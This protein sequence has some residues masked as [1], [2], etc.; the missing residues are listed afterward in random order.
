MGLSATRQGE[1][2]ILSSALFWG[3]FPV[4][5]ILSYDRL[6]P[7]VSLAWSTLFSALFFAVVLTF[8]KSWS[9]IKNKTA[10]R[11]ILWMTLFIGILYYVFFFFGLKYTS[12]G[13]ASIIAL[14]E[15]LASFIFFHVWRKDYIPKEHIIGAALMLVGAAVVLFP[16]VSHWRAGDWLILAAVAV[17]PFGN[18][19]Q[20]RARCQVSSEVI[21]FIRALIATPVIFL[22]AWL[23]GA[24][25]AAIDLRGSLYFL[26]INGCLLLGLTKLFWIEGIHRISVTK[27]NALASLSPLMTL[28]FAW[29]LLHNFPTVWQ[30]LA[31][32]PM[33]FG[34]LLLAR[35][36]QASNPP[37]F[38]D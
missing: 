25:P 16:N 12:A 10:R 2:F 34:V 31:L 18:F 37:V 23:F 19:F 20:Q 35:N 33:F 4:I 11:D 29:L 1:S 5:T 32:V 24:N 38:R 21:M 17:A 22:L 3:L 30:L 27:A 28:L 13:N 15:V 8:K 9:E 26:L 7:L 14:T 6:S 36:G